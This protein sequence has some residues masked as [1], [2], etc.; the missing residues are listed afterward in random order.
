MTGLQF[1]NN[2]QDFYPAGATN[3]LRRNLPDPV[4]LTPR[5]ACRIFR[6]KNRISEVLVFNSSKQT[7][8]KNWILH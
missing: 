7:V 1:V 6:A 5:H 2:M 3:K 4:G 8:A